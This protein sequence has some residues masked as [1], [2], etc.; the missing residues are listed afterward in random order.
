MIKKLYEFSLNK[1]ETVE[2]KVPSKNEAGEEIVE[3]K[4][5]EKKTPIKFFL[6]KPNRV[7]WDDAELYYNVQLSEAIK[8][9]V[10]TAAQLASKFSDEAQ[11]YS[12][13]ERE[14]YI[15]NHLL[16]VDKEKVLGFAEGER[17]ANPSPENTEKVKSLQEEITVVQS[18]ILD[19]EKKQV[20]I[21]E[22]TADS[23]AASKISVWWTLFL[24][25]KDDNTP[26]LGEGSYKEKLAK[27]D[28]LEENGDDFT[29]SVIKKTIYLI[30]FWRANNPTKE[31]FDSYMKLAGFDE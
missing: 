31:Q 19:F 24:L 28:E 6:R 8:S 7:L 18:E 5:T 23:Q 16:L 15:R 25:Y 17:T 29:L 4:K 13:K 3:I 20:N 22:H 2:E 12:N 9:G 10:L 11:T 26:L 14:K 21:Y 27:Y 1:T 30:A